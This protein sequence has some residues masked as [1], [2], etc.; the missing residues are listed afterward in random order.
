MARGRSALCLR[1]VP[2]ETLHGG[3]PPEEEVIPPRG[4]TQVDPEAEAPG[5]TAL[6][7]STAEDGAQ[8]GGESVYTTDGSDEE[9]QPAARHDVVA[10]GEATRHGAGD[11]NTLHGAAD[12]K[13]GRYGRR[14]TPIVIESQVFVLK[15]PTRNTSF[16]HTIDPAPKR[17]IAL[18]KMILSGNAA[19]SRPNVGCS[20]ILLSAYAAPYHAISLSVP[21]SDVILGIAVA[22][23]LIRPH[24][25]A[26]LFSG[27]KR[28]GGTIGSTG[29]GTRRTSTDPEY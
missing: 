22:V 21:K 16:T 4:L 23:V 19:Y 9:G 8:D 13:N 27:V 3:G 11:A 6:G 5:Q 26:C 12:D 20:A 25:Y 14:R 15:G 18:Q 17:P 2:P 10:E 7:E 28:G 29:D 1:S 24:Q